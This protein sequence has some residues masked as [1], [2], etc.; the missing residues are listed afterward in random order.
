M[1]PLSLSRHSLRSGEREN[2]SARLTIDT[3]FDR[4]RR[5][6]A[7][8]R[9]DHLPFLVAGIPAVW[10]FGGF[11]PGYH[12]LSDPVENL[13]FQKME[14][15]IRLA[16]RVAEQVANDTRV[17]RFGVTHRPSTESTSGK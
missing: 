5:L 10:L 8:F 13:Y 11:H 7:P 4:D 12:E 2:R 17:L 3:K 1:K 15:V 9:C 6:N 16:Y 14:K